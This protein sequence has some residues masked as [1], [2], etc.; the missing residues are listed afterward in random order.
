MRLYIKKYAHILLIAAFALIVIVNGAGIIA[1]SRQNI[2]INEVCASNVA[3]CEDDKGNFP[4]WIELYNPTDEPIDLTGFIVSKSADLKKEKFIVPEGIIVAPHSYWLFD[5]GFPISSKGSTINL[6]DPDRHYI[7]HVDTPSLKYD[8]TYARVSDGKNEWE[9]KSPTPG[10]SN[11]EGE[12]LDPVIDGKV[13]A[14]VDP[15]FYE[16][17]FDLKL[18]A[19][20]WGRDIYYTLDG[21][22]PRTDGILYEGPI[23]ITDRS[24]EPNKYSAITETSPQYDR[25]EAELP[26]FNVDKCTVVSAVAKDLLGRYTDVF[27]Y[28]YFVGFN[29]KA[30][31]DNFTVV[32]AVVS[33]DDL[34]S[35]DNGIMVL[36]TDYDGYVEAGRPEEYEGSNAN[37]TRRGRTSEREVSLTVFDENHMPAYSSKAGIRIKGLSSRWDP[38][39]SFNII[40]RNAYSGNDRA[41]FTTD[42]RD[43]DR[44]SLCL[45]KCGQDT[46]TKMMDII[47]ERCM[48]DTEC[49]TNDGVPCALF[50]NGEYWGMY[51]L[52]DRIDETYLADEYGVVKDDVAIIDSEDMGDAGISWDY[53]FL[54]RESLIEY[55][56]ANIIV[57]HNGDWPAYNVRFWYTTNDE[58]TEYGNGKLRPVIFDMN[59]QSMLDAGYDV[60]ECLME[61]YP[62]ATASEDPQFRKDLAAKIDEMCENEFDKDKVEGMI[63]SVCKKIRPQMILDKTRF[64]NCSEEEAAKSFDDNT[65]LI[66]RFYETRWEPLKAQKDRYVNGE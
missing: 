61:W 36:G 11:E 46:D 39:K 28:T 14:N 56:A 31:Y 48:K 17:D 3:S 25:G 66:R 65:A 42:G 62:F 58:G 51:W 64:S 4:D 5:P 59:S 52:M 21:S 47:M 40:F 24:S 13:K 38:Q 57:A 18:K 33:P 27:T 43:F 26:A 16:K 50:L 44:H 30:A 32:S 63:D 22:D 20:N 53:D 37:F 41:Q 54:D 15:G 8:T 49:A 19:T 23:H 60:I 9:I 10:Y 45:D 35:H 2:V 12:P 34:F 7:D 1:R 6:V 29:D 55:Y